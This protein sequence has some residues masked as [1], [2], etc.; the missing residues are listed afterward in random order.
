MCA[1]ITIDLELATLSSKSPLFVYLDNNPLTFMEDGLTYIIPCAND[2][3][4]A[5]MG[6]G[7]SASVL[8]MRLRIEERALTLPQ[9]LSLRE[10]G[11]R[12]D[13]C[14]RQA[15][16]I[17]LLMKGAVQKQIWTAPNIYLMMHF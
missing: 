7:S 11:E 4:L 3:S 16:P 6:S 15:A 5:N 17:D 8:R 14:G 9:V 2:R 1:R 13:L 10:I 12:L